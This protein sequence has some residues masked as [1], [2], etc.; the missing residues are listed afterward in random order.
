MEAGFLGEVVLEGAGC[1][2]VSAEVSEELGGF[3]VVGEEEEGLVGVAGLVH[4]VEDGGGGCDAAVSV[5]SWRVWT[6]ALLT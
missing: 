5:G 2:V 1:V 3:D 4:H 6:L